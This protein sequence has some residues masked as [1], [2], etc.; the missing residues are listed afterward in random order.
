[1]ERDRISKQKVFLIMFTYEYLN[2]FEM[3]YRWDPC[4][5]TLPQRNYTGV[6]LASGIQDVLNG[7]AVTFD[8]EIIYHPARSTISIQAKSEGM[9]SHNLFYI[10]SDL[11]ITTWENNS[12]SE[13]D[14]E[15]REGVVQTL[16]INNL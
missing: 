10:P 11:G 7:F 2:E 5:L 16:E 14:W 3:A 13:N 9:D 15:N 1:M 12:Y 6:T 4:V 8:F